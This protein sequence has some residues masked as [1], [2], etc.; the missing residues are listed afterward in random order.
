MKM[1]TN[2]HQLSN[3]SSEQEVFRCIEKIIKLLELEEQNSKVYNILSEEIG[4]L[5]KKLDDYHS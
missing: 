5:A 4:M 1:I 2:Q 3:S